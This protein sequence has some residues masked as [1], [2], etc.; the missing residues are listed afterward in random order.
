[1]RTAFLGIGLVMV[2]SMATASAQPSNDDQQAMSGPANS[3]QSDCGPA[4]GRMMMGGMMDRGGWGEHE[5]G[6]GEWHHHEH[7]TTAAMFRIKRDGTEI[8]IRCS[9]MEQTQMC[10]Q[11]AM[12]LIDK[13]ASGQAGS[14]TPR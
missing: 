1:M 7:Q 14:S 13:M 8:D 4:M 3:Q 10:V 6:R 9:E 5:D 11:G 12:T 2:F